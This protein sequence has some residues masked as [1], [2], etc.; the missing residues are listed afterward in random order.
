MSWASLVGIPDP[1]PQEDLPGEGLRSG[2]SPLGGASGASPGFLKRFPWDP[3]KCFWAWEEHSLD[4][5]RKGFQQGTF[6]PL[7]IN[8]DLLQ[9]T[10]EVGSP[11]GSTKGPLTTR[12]R[13][14]SHIGYTK[15]PFGSPLLEIQYKLE[16]AYILWVVFI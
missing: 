15:G 9:P 3:W 4:P 10:S 8:R 12:A 14:A 11:F 7:P 16:I 5:Q 2:F 1:S 6:N 13:V